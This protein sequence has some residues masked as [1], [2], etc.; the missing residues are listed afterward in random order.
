MA[1]KDQSIAVYYTDVGTLWLPSGCLN[2]TESWLTIVANCDATPTGSNNCPTHV[3]TSCHYLHFTV[4]PKTGKQPKQENSPK[5]QVSG[6]SPKQQTSTQSDISLHHSNPKRFRFQN[7]VRSVHIQGMGEE[8]QGLFVS[9]VHQQWVASDAVWKSGCVAESG[10]GVN[11]P[12]D[13]RRTRRRED[14]AL[15]R[16]PSRR[17]TTAQMT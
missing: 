13:E 3:S 12:L 14:P 11:D 2:E 6:N 10:H 17:S 1:I 4:P 8:G 7:Q 5:Q 9:T 16:N 15:E